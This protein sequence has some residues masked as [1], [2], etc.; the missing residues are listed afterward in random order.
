MANEFTSMSERGWCQVC[1]DGR[2]PPFHLGGVE[3]EGGGREG[4]VQ[5][6]VGGKFSYCYR[7]CCSVWSANLCL[8]LVTS[9]RYEVT[10]IYHSTTVRKLIVP[11]DLLP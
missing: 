3:G 1:V 4:R 5:L 11:V 8:H 10:F 9:K 2:L 7:C 6:L